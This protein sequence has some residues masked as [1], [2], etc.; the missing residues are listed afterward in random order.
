MPAGSSVRLDPAG[1]HL[2]LTGMA[3]PFAEGG[4]LEMTLHFQKAGDVPVQLNIGGFA[5]RTPPEAADTGASSDEMSGMDM[6][7]MSS[8]AM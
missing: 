6:S 7:G 3:A 8:M 4:C 5:Q 2:M 1:D